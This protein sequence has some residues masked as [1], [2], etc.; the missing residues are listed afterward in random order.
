MKRAVFLHGTNGDP[1]DHWWPWLKKH[2]EDSGY[3]VWAP[4]LPGN[5]KPNEEVYRKF[6]MSNDWTFEDNVLVGH[7]SGA[8]TVLNLLARNDFP[9]VKAAV[10]AGVFLNEDLTSKSADFVQT[11]QFMNLFPKAG[12]DWRAIKEKSEKFYFVH[13]DDDPYCSY[14]DALEACRTLDGQMITVKD[15]GHLS[16]NFNVTEL[17][18]LVDSLQRDMIL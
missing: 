17:P 1:G 13:G 9:P 11:G 3:E 15:G 7:S 8:T 5:D 6:L 14:T 16:T 12:F 10:L 2:F 18:Q 4:V